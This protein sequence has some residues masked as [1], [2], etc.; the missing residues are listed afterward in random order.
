MSEALNIDLHLLILITICSGVGGAYRQYIQARIN[1]PDSDE[2]FEKPFLSVL[3]G[4]TS[5]EEIMFSLSLFG[6]AILSSIF[7]QWWSGIVVILSFYIIGRKIIGG[8]LSALIPPRFNTK[9]IW[10]KF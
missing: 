3:F 9:W 7:F 4:I 5:L 2:S 10:I 8:M 6:V 1:N